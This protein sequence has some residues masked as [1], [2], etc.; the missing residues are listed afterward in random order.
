MSH[1]AYEFALPGGLSTVHNVFHASMI[2]KYFPNPS[3]VL[4]QV[5]I[6]LQKGL[7]YEDKPIQIV[8]E[9]E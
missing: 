7:S 1:K 4:E 6:E 8:D 2:L 3:Q 9:K 5:D